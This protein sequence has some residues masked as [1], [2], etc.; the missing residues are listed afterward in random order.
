ME[1]LSKKAKWNFRLDF[2]PLFF[3]SSFITFLILLGITGYFFPGILSIGSYFWVPYLL[4]FCFFAFI[5]PE[6]Y[7]RLFYNNFYYLL[8]KD[9]IE[10]KKGVLNKKNIFIEYNT[11]Q[12]L[13]IK[14]GLIERIFNFSELE[15][16]TNTPGDLN[17][18]KLF[19]HRR[20]Y[21]RPLERRSQGYL[22][23]I[24]VEVAEN[25]KKIISKKSN[26]F[27]SKI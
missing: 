14:R 5:F 17:L 11:I 12:N 6:I 20:D 2:F 24:E 8:G 21:S 22:P 25:L 1:R 3:M 27:Q 26:A 4:L 13:E 18:F 9:G 16:Y 10:I 23:G 19:I 7:V 15:I